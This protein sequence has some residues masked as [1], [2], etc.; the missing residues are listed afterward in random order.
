MVA[1][2]ICFIILGCFETKTATQKAREYLLHD[3]TRAVQYIQGLSQ[4]EQIY[5]VTQLSE[6]FP[7]RIPPLC[8]VIIGEAQKRC[9]RIAKRPHLW[10]NPTQSH[11]EQ[12]TSKDCAHPH[13]CFEQE[14]IHSIEQG[15][16]SKAIK[17]CT[18]IE[19][20]KWAHEC[21]FHCSEYLLKQ[22]TN[23]YANTLP[24][25]EQSGSFRNNCI[26]HGIFAIATT[27][28]RNQY[29]QKQ[30][31]KKIHSIKKIWDKHNKKES[32]IRIDQLWAH[33]M[34]R[35]AEDNTIHFDLLPS[36]LHAH[37]H[38]NIALSGV[39]FAIEIDLNLEHHVEQLQ[40]N[41]LAKHSTRRGMEPMMNL[42]NNP[43]QGKSFLGYSFRLTDSNP[44]IDLLIATLESIARLQPPQMSRI[45]PYT[46]HTNPKVQATAKR[47]LQF[48]VTQPSIKAIVYVPQ[49]L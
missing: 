31:E 27:W 13:I 21:I 15:N 46:K 17:A 45:V 12:P 4:E 24:I 33:W 22:D 7:Q 38:S 47:L 6:E 26:Q 20:P 23:Q 19:D 41:I 43:T 49:D 1:I 29:T 35:Y 14:A 3:P 40:E 42:W 8:N 44:K 9:F 16:T 2:F 30:V 37:Y 39:Q 5:I 48:D 36:H 34:Y 18:N 32:S 25:C 28:L 11:I 10:N